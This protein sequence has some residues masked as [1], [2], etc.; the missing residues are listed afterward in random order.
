MQE[1]NCLL[2]YPRCKGNAEI[3]ADVVFF[4]V[5]GDK[6]ISLHVGTCSLLSFTER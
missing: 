4:E 2:V 3:E 6:Q 1:N 5:T